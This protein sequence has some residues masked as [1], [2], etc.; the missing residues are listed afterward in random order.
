L[1]NIGIIGT[2]FGSV[3]Q[4]PGF[5]HHPDFLP[6]A[7]AGRHK[8]KTDTIAKRLNIEN[9]YSNWKDMLKLDDLDAVSI[10]TPPHLHKEMTLAAL[11]SGKHVICEKPLSL[12]A[13]DAEEMLLKSEESGLINMLDLVFRFI[14]SRAH[15]LELIK[16]DYL[17]EIY[18]CDIT[19][20]N[21]SRLNPR[22]RGYNWWSSQKKGGGILNALGAHYIDFLLQIFGTIERV[23]GKTATNIPKRLNKM[24]GRMKTV[25]ADD[26]FIALFD[27]GDNV[28]STMKISSTSPY[29][30]GPKI[31]IYGSEGTL[32]M[33]EDQSLIGGKLGENKKLQP[34]EI[35]AALKLNKYSDEDH[36]LVPPFVRLLDEFSK[37]IKTGRSL[38]PN[39]ED[40]FRIQQILD[41]IRLS[42][43]KMSWISIE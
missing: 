10:V 12:N 17:G 39:F 33:L 16:N 13:K 11:D 41:A 18:Q 37:S 5:S 14:P 27:V 22:T 38:H 42:N 28:L 19:V 3:V 43:S 15:M 8:S 7:I 36:L 30:R 9:S 4:Y 23:S 2:G 32:M 31:E 21:S 24:T 34:I 26:S 40:G 25:S 6:I 35:P 20:H 29:G 1:N